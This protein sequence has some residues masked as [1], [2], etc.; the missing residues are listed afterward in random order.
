MQKFENSSV[1]EAYIE[2]ALAFEAPMA[3]YF[4]RFVFD[5]SISIT[6]SPKSSS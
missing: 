2:I 4:N 3:A 1:E 6:A 5:A